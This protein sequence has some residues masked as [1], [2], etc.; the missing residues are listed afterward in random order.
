M[1]STRIGAA[2]DRRHGGD[3]SFRPGSSRDMTHLPGDLQPDPRTEPRSPSGPGSPPAARGPGAAVR[4]PDALV[5]NGAFV[6][7]AT[8]GLPL[9]DA[10]ER[11]VALQKRCP[12][13]EVD[14]PAILSFCPRDGAVLR[15]IEAPA[16]LLGHALAGRFQIVEKLGSGG[17]GTVYRAQHIRLGRPC[18]VKVLN[19]VRAHDHDAI[20]HFEREAS[21]ASRISHPNVVAVYDFGETEDGLLFLA[22][23]YVEG[24][25]LS[26][27]G[28][29]EG[30][31]PPRRAADIVRQIANGLSAAH[32]LG[33]VHRDL[34]PDNVMVGRN[35]DGSDCVKV[36]DF[37]IAKSVLS[38]SQSLTA[39]GMIIGTPQYMSP[40]Q[41]SGEQADA[42][43]DV[44]ALGLIAYWLL[45]AAFPFPTGGDALL[46]RLA[47]PPRPL[48][49]VR[50]DVAWPESLQRVLNR[51]LST[52]A[53]QRY[54]TAEA[55]CR[56]LTEA[57]EA[58]QSTLV[59]TRRTPAVHDA[60]S[61]RVSRSRRLVAA[62][63]AVV[64]TTLLASW[65][66]SSVAPDDPVVTPRTEL[67]GSP[68]S[69]GGETGAPA[70]GQRSTIASP[71]DRARRESGR[72][73]APV[74]PSTAAQRSP[75]VAAASPASDSLAIELR[76]L[77]EW[78]DPLSGGESSA[79]RALAQLP[80]LLPRLT[81]EADSVEAE[82]YGVSAHLLLGDVRAACALL[83]RLEGRAARHAS[84]TNAVESYLADPALG[85]R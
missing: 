57:V 64:A 66:V 49:E 39:T 4:A 37:G 30:A 24:E 11:Q 50:P 28:A 13:C 15:S 1:L 23:E 67:D 38:R 55:F 25:P 85:C 44:Y 41:L 82:Y 18:A 53:A 58:W 43:T 8:P 78:T 69:S 40:E 9:G 26:A 52:S 70:S 63:G 22:M 3:P 32:E 71:D 54:A 17:M 75:I 60:P 84:F 72:A 48:S 12:H 74:P 76:R 65:A 5:W 62:L 16:E 20:A 59:P 81:S 56:E 46:M 29:R 61:R 42:R 2:P 35:R 27:L 21:N 10:P 36:V 31:L 14:Y 34:K 45:T 80:I 47:A 83:I 73:P 6:P 7:A 79:R 19:T 68:P 51:A 77:R 33:I